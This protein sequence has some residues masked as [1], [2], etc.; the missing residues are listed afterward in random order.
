M[1]HDEVIEFEEELRKVKPFIDEYINSLPDS[2]KKD[3]LREDFILVE[4]V[5]IMCYY[6]KGNSRSNTIA[7]WA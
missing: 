3:F 4:L 6:L 1:T 7:F 5:W 2:S